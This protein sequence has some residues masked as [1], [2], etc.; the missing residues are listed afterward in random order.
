MMEFLRILFFA[1]TVLLTPEPINLL[2]D[3]ELRPREPLTAITAGASIEI[4]VSSMITKPR[5]ESVEDFYRRA[6][7]MFPSG[8]AE[9]KLLTK[10]KREVVLNYD[11][12]GIAFS[13]DTV[14][15]V[16]SADGGVP[17]DIEFEIVRL[18]SRIELQSVKVT[19][20]NYKH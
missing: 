14:F 2:G 10:D 3:V 16:L 1:K 5:Q 8:A 19:W 15:L 4:D 9:A 13:N 20:K 18:T 12:R 17:T 7:A 6:E 11:Q